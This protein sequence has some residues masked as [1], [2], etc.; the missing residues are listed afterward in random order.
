MTPEKCYDIIRR[1]VITEKSMRGAEWNQ[2]TFQVDRRATKKEIRQAIETIFGVTVKA[3]NTMNQTGKVK[4]FRGRLG[5]RNAV[6]KA[7]VTLAE[8][9]RIDVTGTL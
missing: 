3:V 2:V 7:V 1:P 9:Q 5:R 4:R 6:K 8:G